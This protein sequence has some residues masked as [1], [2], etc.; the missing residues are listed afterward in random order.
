MH[1]QEMAPAEEDSM[2]GCRYRK[3]KQRDHRNILHL[4]C[5]NILTVIEKMS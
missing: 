5:M 1:S 3:Q 2:G 4:L